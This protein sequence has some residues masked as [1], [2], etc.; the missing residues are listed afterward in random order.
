VGP[1]PGAILLLVAAVFSVLAWLGPWFT[2]SF[3]GLASDSSVGRDEYGALWGILVLGLAVGG[4]AVGFLN[5]PAPQ[6]LRVTAII[7]AGLLVAVYMLQ[8]ADWFSDY[9]DVSGFADPGWAAIISP[10]IPVLA[11]LGAIFFKFVPS[12][13]SARP[14]PAAGWG[15]SATPPPPRSSPPPPPAAPW[16]PAAS[17]PPPP[18]TQPQPQ[19]PPVPAPGGLEVGTGKQPKPPSG[20]DPAPEIASYTDVAWYRKTW[21]MVLSLLFFPPVAIVVALTGEMYQKANRRMRAISAAEVWRYNDRGRW[22]VVG[23]A[24]AFLLLGWVRIVLSV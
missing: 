10:V 20:L 22:I 24:A 2:L 18:S 23:V 1:N 11:V 3:A 9:T 12:S 21:L 15:A 5:R 17:Q 4:M 19:P 16:S 14:A 6:G 7:S 8:A 13:G